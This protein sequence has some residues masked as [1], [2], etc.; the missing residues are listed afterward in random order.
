MLVDGVF[1]DKNNQILLA[2]FQL[3]PSIGLAENEGDDTEDDVTTTS[4]YVQLVLTWRVIQT[5]EEDHRQYE[6]SGYRNHW[7]T[8]EEKEELY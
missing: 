4:T 8:P 3:L 6:I 5:T 1:D 7:L 2:D